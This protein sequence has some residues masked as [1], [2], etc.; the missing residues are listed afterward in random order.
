MKEYRTEQ[1]NIV[2]IHGSVNIERVKSASETFLKKAEKAR[3][4]RECKQ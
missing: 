2:R 1:G 4:E 3:R